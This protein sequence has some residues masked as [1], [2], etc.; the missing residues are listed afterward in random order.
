MSFLT[1]FSGMTPEALNAR[2]D[3]IRLEIEN[4]KLENEK[5]RLLNENLHLR[6]MSQDR[7]SEEVLMN[8]P[9][10]SEEENVVLEPI[11]EEKDEVE[12]LD[13][14]I[15]NTIDITSSSI[16]SFVFNTKNE[17]THLDQKSLTYMGI[18]RK[19]WEITPRQKIYD[20]SIFAMKDYYYSRRGFKWI[21]EIQLSAQVGSNTMDILREIINMSSLMKYSFKMKVILSDRDIIDISLSKNN[22]FLVENT[23]NTTKKVDKLLYNSGGVWCYRN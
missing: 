21:P 16:L 12:I 3:T 7:L 14:S 15:L 9:I 4:L 20:H 11:A 17:D 19:V 1:D 13:I 6:S 22:E 18:L 10:E 5:L 23:N 8:T 2:I